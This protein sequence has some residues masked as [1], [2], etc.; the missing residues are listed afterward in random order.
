MHDY[1]SGL[2]RRGNFFVQTV[3]T[4]IFLYRGKQTALLTFKL[5]SKRHQH[6]R[7]GRP[8][9]QRFRNLYAKTFDSRRHE[10][11][12]SANRYLRAGRQ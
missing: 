11:L 4:V 7:A 6:V 8:L 2:R 5:K 3:E 1:S 9:F 12:G 10:R